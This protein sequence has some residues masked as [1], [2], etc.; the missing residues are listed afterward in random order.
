MKSREKDIFKVEEAL[1]RFHRRPET[2]EARPFWAKKLMARVRAE[3]M[4]L[5][6][7]S[8][9]GGIVWRL[10]SVTCLLAVFLA[11][12]ASGLNVETQYQVVEL[13]FDEPSGLDLAHLFASL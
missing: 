4:P 3:K 9:A 2:Y 10:A 5:D 13:I 6:D 7:F 11:F 12:Y 8:R 1:I